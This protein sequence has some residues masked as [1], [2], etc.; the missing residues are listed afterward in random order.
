MICSRISHDSPS[1]ELISKGLRSLSLSDADSSVAFCCVAS[2][3]A[4]A[5]AMAEAILALVVFTSAREHK[6]RL[7]TALKP[8]LQYR[9]R[10][11][12]QWQLIY[13]FGFC[14]VAWDQPHAIS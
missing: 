11:L 5:E 8:S 1:R 14:F 2:K 10:L 7:G 13:D 4:L 6:V 12:Y 3:L 9:L